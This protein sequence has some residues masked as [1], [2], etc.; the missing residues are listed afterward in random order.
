MK[1][2]NIFKCK[3]FTESEN[4]NKTC[5]NKYMCKIYYEIECFE[6]EEKK[7]DKE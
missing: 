2:Q 6:Y 4:M 3:Y 5:Q 7:D 1:I